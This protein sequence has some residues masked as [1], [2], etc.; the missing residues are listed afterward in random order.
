MIWLETDLVDQDREAFKR[1]LTENLAD[2]L[3]LPP[4]EVDAVE[5]VLSSLVHFYADRLL[6]RQIP[7]EL[8]VFL[9]ARGL[10][11]VGERDLARRVARH[12]CRPHISSMC[13]VPRLTAANAM[14]LWK[15]FQAGALKRSFWISYDR[16][17]WVLDMRQIDVDPPARIEV[18][19]S[20][21]LKVVLEG[22]FQVWDAGA[23]DTILR[24]KGLDTF[25][26]AFLTLPADA[27]PVKSLGGE[28]EAYA[29]AVAVRVSAASGW[30]FIPVIEIH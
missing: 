3:C 26:A 7:D 24:I 17:V 12:R 9:L 20:R 16:E 13:S 21:T 19:A 23:P 18:Y 29:R 10:W 22:I 8:L 27:P 1:A 2:E 11:S 14:L 30:D 5:E 25:A 15:L 4:S 28:L 6:S